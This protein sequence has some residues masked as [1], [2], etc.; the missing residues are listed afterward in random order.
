M[1]LLNS[2]RLRALT[3]CALISVAFV[4][5]LLPA[6]ASAQGA[7]AKWVDQAT[8]SYNGILYKED[9]A[10]D[11]NW[12]FYGTNAEGCREEIDGLDYAAHKGDYKQ[13]TVT[14]HKQKKVAAG[15][16]SNGKQDITL[17]KS[18]PNYQVAFIWKDDANIETADGS[19]KFS[20]DT[21]GN[22]IS[23]K[24]QSA[25]KDY[26]TI[27]EDK[28]EVKLV[29]RADA[30]FADDAQTDL[31]RKYGKDY[32]TEVRSG[33]AFHP[34]IDSAGDVTLNG[35][36]CHQ[37]KAISVPANDTAARTGGTPITPGTG[38]NQVQD[39]NSCET[40]S[41][42]MG[43]IMC[44]VIFAL[45]GAINW[46]DSRINE[47]LDIDKGYYDNPG[48]KSAWRTIRNLAYIILVPVMLVM[49]LGTALGFDLI[50]AYTVKRAL[51]RLVAAAI[52]ISLSYILCTFLIEFANNVGKG[53]MGLLLS[54]FSDA[55][56]GSFSKDAHQLEL[57]DL[58]GGNI[59]TSLFVGIPVAAVGVV[60][61]LAL[62]GGTLL[63]F[64]M[65]AFLILLLRQI[66][67]VALLLLAP[68]AILAWIFPGND[69]LWKAWWSLFSKLLLMYPLIVG[70]IAAGRIFAFIIDQSNPAGLDGAVLAPLMTVVAWIVP[71]AFI[72]FTFK[73][74]GGMFATIS[75]MANDRSKGLFDRQ[76]QKRAA[77]LKRFQEDRAI[78]AH[79][80]DPS[81]VRGKLAK[82]ANTV[83]SIATS[84]P[85]DTARLYGK[86][87]GGKAL[88]S[89]IEGKKHLQTR[90]LNEEL[91]KHGITT[92]QAFRAI[93]GTHQGV[94]RGMG[95][96]RT[97]KD[98]D[99]A[100]QK[101]N[102]SG[103]S[104]DRLAAQQLNTARGFL[105]HA[106][107]SEEYGRASIEG[108]GLLGLA[109]QG[110]AD[111]KDIADVS[112]FMGGGQAAATI[113][114]DASFL[115]YKAG[116]IDMKP[117]YG[118]QWN[119]GALGGKGAF[120]EVAEAQMQE[121]LVK[122]TK[123]FEWS[124]AKGDAVKELSGAIQRVVAVG[125]ADSYTMA[126]TVASN[127]MSQTDPGSKAE[128]RKLAG[129]I[130]A[131]DVQAQMA[132]GVSQDEAIDRVVY[133]KAYG[134]GA[135]NPNI[136]NAQGLGPA[137]GGPGGPG[138]GPGGPAAGGP[139]APSDRRLKRNIRELVVLDSGI[140]LYKFQYL[141]SDQEY[142]GVMAQDI[143]STHPF[144]IST[145]QNGYYKV[146]YSAL[147]IRMLTVEEWKHS[148]EKVYLNGD[149]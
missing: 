141:W 118:P 144:A 116:R 132:T 87:A 59:F 51:P 69:K 122:S 103:N 53:T 92:D 43:W 73:F 47:L 63:L 31:K 136:Q 71:Y 93:S 10:Q 86:T 148:Q 142:V 123:Q 13:Q 39:D 75:G 107:S 77:R 149:V 42:A 15:C 82:R 111:R 5:P 99:S 114:N 137:A 131:Q 96:L 22:F 146:S 65:I 134:R 72:P 49:V 38:S 41:G 97:S 2:V 6:Q 67:V 145:D 17:L 20:R 117:S 115:S 57:A 66:F 40:R 130:F 101:L 133:E 18:P 25:C 104:N 37:S 110:F 16:A 76:R 4:L 62:F 95:P 106:F 28:S 119:A 68:L 138:P 36:S 1:L 85:W 140:Q 12:H 113:G 98:I 120:S 89:E 70:V 100:I 24:D 64:A 126:Q 9:D 125:D 127:A 21:D 33:Y 7:T 34:Q 121:K 80:Y 61:L 108:A 139:P 78:N 94:L 14:L 50:S 3:L 109:S 26:L 35:K 11:D 81:S 83:A 32:E 19:R 102:A 105:A 8:I 135:M 88:L 30:R 124:G 29:I 128:W 27:G 44:P 46:I 54:P 52:F 56:Y 45:E 129:S 48:V 147:G 60:V 112:K 143:L 91:Q 55:I 58:V 79:K 74:A 23:L 84:N 90:A